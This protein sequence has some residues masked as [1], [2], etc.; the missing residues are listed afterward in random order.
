MLL[1]YDATFEYIPGRKHLAPDELFCRPEVNAVSIIS[2]SSALHEAIAA[3][4]AKSTDTTFLRA[5]A[6]A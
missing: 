6:S 3:A 2:D 1:E 5:K 4:Q